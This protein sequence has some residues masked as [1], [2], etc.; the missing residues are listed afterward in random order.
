MT[1][2]I[3]DN[4]LPDS[5]V[6]RRRQVRERIRDLRQ[7]VRRFRESNVPGPDVVESAENE[8]T[9]LRNRII[10]RDTVVDRIRARRA[11]S[12]GTGSSSDDTS[13]GGSDTSEMSSADELL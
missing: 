8:L 2:L 5:V 13:N 3:G 4:M 7:P 11:S 9:S 6:S 1:K 12:S 10:S